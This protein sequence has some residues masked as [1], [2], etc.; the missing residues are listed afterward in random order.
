MPELLKP[1]LISRLRLLAGLP[2]VE[3]EVFFVAKV[4]AFVFVVGEHRNNSL[5]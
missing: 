5:G 2:P 4:H 1:A 3:T